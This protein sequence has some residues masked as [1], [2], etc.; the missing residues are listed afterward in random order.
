M[1]NTKTSLPVRL[2][3]LV[4]ILTEVTQTST[5]TPKAIKEIVAQAAVAPEDLLPYA[6]FDHPV[7]DCYGR[8]M[9]YDGG[10]FE[11]MAM[12]WNPNHY[13]SIHNH[14]YTEWGIVQVFGPAHHMMYHLKDRM[15][16]TSVREILSPGAIIKVNNAL[17]HQ[18]GNPTTER[19]QTLHIYG[20]N[21]K[22]GDITADATNFDL[23]FNRTVETTGGAF[24]NLPEDQ[25]YSVKEGLSADEDTFMFYAHLLL[26]YYNRQPKSEKISALK[27]QLMQKIAGMGL[28]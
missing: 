5:L 21:S 7:E 14:G 20:C 28:N 25:Y 15:L 9:V 16:H 11:V 17:I 27:A 8:K 22:D 12:S 13:S 24:F 4:D 19:F 10:K 1:I 6:D 18:M 2:Q 23:E 3:K 26:D